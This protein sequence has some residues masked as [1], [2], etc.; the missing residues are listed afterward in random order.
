V[1]H[2]SLVA[3]LVL[4][5]AP[6]TQAFAQGPLPGPFRERPRNEPLAAPTR[7]VRTI[8]ANAGE[9]AFCSACS[10]TTR[11]SAGL[12]GRFCERTGNNFAGS[13][14]TLPFEILDD[15]LM[16]L[17]LGA[18]RKSAEV[19]AS[20]CLRVDLP[21]IKPVSAR[22]QFADHDGLGAVLLSE[23]GATM[24]RPESCGLSDEGCGVLFANPCAGRDYGV[25]GG[26]ICDP[27]PLPRV[28]ARPGRLPLVRESGQREA[29][30]KR[31]W[32]MQWQQ[33]WQKMIS[34]HAPQLWI[35]FFRNA[36][37][38]S[39]FL[40]VRPLLSLMERA[41]RA[42]SYRRTGGASSF[43]PFLRCLSSG[44]SSASTLWASLI[45]SSASR[46]QFSLTQSLSAAS[47]LLR[48]SSA[49]RHRPRSMRSLRRL[50][51]PM[52]TWSAVE[53]R[54]LKNNDACR[55]RQ[56]DRCT[57]FGSRRRC[58]HHG[59]ADPR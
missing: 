28:R 36:A 19:A 34:S 41:S 32:P 6:A 4:I 47:A 25:R 26:R 31:L 44:A 48:A 11:S 15:A 3:C 46:S 2:K 20:P 30:R 7:A 57:C 38:A 39:L 5:T 40:A 16:L 37:C 14:L 24:D 54:K 50:V 8:P 10:K 52:Q 56:H 12:A 13:H 42:E 9:G 35:G 22:F 17:R 23:V 51:N 58:I 21:R 27:C 49:W 18:R 59:A 53:C 55:L 33:Q 43:A 29:A 1:F 45:Q